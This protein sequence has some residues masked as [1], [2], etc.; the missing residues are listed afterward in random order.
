MS[1]QALCFVVIVK[2]KKEIYDECV[3]CLVRDETASRDAAL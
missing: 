3:S 2:L 1:L